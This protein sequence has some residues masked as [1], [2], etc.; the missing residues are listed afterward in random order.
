M[1]GNDLLT[2]YDRLVAESYK[3][4]GH[5]M[6]HGPGKVV[7]HMKLLEHNKKVVKARKALLT[8]LNEIELLQANNDALREAAQAYMSQ[9]GQGYAA[10][11][12]SFGPSQQ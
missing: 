2:K 9:I 1:T 10:H 11:G 3:L 7:S 8:Q 6:S 5:S 4:A 12:L